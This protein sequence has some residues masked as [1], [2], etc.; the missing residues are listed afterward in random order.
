MP[1]SRLS[2]RTGG[3]ASQLPDDGTGG[4]VES[5]SLGE[6]TVTYHSGQR[7]KAWEVPFSFKPPPPQLGAGTPHAGVNLYDSW[8]KADAR[9]SVSAILSGSRSEALEDEGLEVS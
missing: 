2:F 3:R 6:E 5:V 4:G 9:A 7:A 1:S 8:H